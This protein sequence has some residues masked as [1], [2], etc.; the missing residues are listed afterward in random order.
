[1]PFFNLLLVLDINLISCLLGLL[2]SKW[3]NN[4]HKSS[5]SSLQNG[6]RLYRFEDK[7]LCDFYAE[8]FSLIQLNVHSPQY[9]S[10]M[11]VCVHGYMFPL[12]LSGVCALSD[13]WNL[14]ISMC[15]CRSHRRRGSRSFSGYQSFAKPEYWWFPGRNASWDLWEGNW[16]KN[17]SVS[18]WFYMLP[19]HRL[20]VEVHQWCV[21]CWIL[22]FG[23]KSLF[24]WSKPK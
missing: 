20:F 1:M 19:F 5:R 21:F 16:S 2:V 6:I 7:W 4:I 24:Y 15:C 3:P 14:L 17:S 13:P 22:T 18:Y 23:G 8:D 9:I 10:Y 11:C 12:I